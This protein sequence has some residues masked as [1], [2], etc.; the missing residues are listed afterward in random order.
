M[1]ATT[2]IDSDIISTPAIKAE[3]RGMA[4][5][6][7]YPLHTL[8]ESLKNLRESDRAALKTR[9]RALA[10][11]IAE[12]KSRL[13]ESAYLKGQAQAKAE[14]AVQ[15]CDNA[16]QFKRLIKDAKRECLQLTLRIAEQVTGAAFVGQPNVLANKIGA[17]LRQMGAKS[18]ITL[19]VNPTQLSELDTIFKDREDHHLCELKASEEVEAGN[20]TI[21]TG[22]GKVELRWKEQLQGVAARLLAALRAEFEV[23]KE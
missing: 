14:L 3:Y 7:P 11:R 5:S 22:F 10:C 17:A 1:E 21:E 19:R 12:L 8:R 6:E 2:R 20:V 13:K 23:E 9:R 16:R 4:D 15:L 18:G